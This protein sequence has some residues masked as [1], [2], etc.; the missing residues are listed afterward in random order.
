[1]STLAAEWGTKGLRINAIEG[2][3]HVSPDHGWQLLRYMA[4]AGAQYLT[5]QT[6]CLNQN[7]SGGFS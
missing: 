5:G 7:A 3:G 6:L 4:G 1:V 2:V